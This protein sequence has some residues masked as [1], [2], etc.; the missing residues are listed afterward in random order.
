[1]ENLRYDFEKIFGALGAD[2][3]HRFSL[4][5]RVVCDGL[6]SSRVVEHLEKSYEN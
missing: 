4:N 5:T 6:G 2:L 1:M 3:M